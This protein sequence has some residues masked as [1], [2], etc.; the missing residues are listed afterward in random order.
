MRLR[1]VLFGTLSL[2]FFVCL[3]FGVALVVRVSGLEGVCNSAGAWGMSVPGGVSII[4]LLLVGILF[5]REWRQDQT[6]SALLPW[7]LLMAAGGSNL[8]E[9]LYFGCVMDYVRW[10]TLPTFNLADVVLT[11]SVV[12]L[13]VKGYKHD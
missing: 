13:V 12:F 3:L 5:F 8:L 7:L 2:A 11:V 4:A 1:N 10:L 6:Q 9:R